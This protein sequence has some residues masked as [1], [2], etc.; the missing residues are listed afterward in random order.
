MHITETSQAIPERLLYSPKYYM[1][2]LNCILKS[3]LKIVH[4]ERIGESDDMIWY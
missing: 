1:L 4:G 3:L 2:N